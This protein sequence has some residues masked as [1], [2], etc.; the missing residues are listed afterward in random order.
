LAHWQT[1]K[2]QGSGTSHDAQNRFGI[3]SDGVGKKP[4]S[5]RCGGFWVRFYDNFHVSAE[6]QRPR[7]SRTSFSKRWINPQ[8]HSTGFFDSS[9]KPQSRR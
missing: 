9:R 2:G 5:H 8:V 6:N 1:V 7:A 4:G 3:L